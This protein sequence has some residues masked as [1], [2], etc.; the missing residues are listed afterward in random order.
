[1]IVQSAYYYMLTAANSWESETGF[2]E[3]KNLNNQNIQQATKKCKN[4]FVSNVYDLVEPTK[5]IMALS[6]FS[7]C[8]VY[9]DESIFGIY[10][11]LLFI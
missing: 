8:I 10:F 1:M 3:G 6:L 7:K 11:L 5:I 9:P 2:S 4:P